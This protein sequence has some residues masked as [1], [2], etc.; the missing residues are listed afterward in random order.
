MVVREAYWRKYTEM[1]EK[2]EMEERKERGQKEKIKGG[3][4]RRGGVRDAH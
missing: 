4:L 1:E 2:E 3:R